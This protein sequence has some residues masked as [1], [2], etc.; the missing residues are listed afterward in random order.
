[1]VVGPVPGAT[2]RGTEAPRASGVSGTSGLAVRGLC[3]VHRGRLLARLPPVGGVAYLAQVRARRV[4]ALCRRTLD[5]QY[6]SGP[7]STAVCSGAT[8]L[9]L[10]QQQRGRLVNRNLAGAAKQ[11]SV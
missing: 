10:A 2:G 11:G 6:G 7:C 4:R 3:S 8:V 1:M 9:G 5:V